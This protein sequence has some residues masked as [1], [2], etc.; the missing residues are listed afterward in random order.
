MKMKLY[1]IFIFLNILAASFF[2]LQSLASPSTKDV[3][4]ENM[5]FNPEHL[6]IHP[7]D[8]VVWNN[9]DIVSHTVTE[10]KELFNSGEVKPGAS[11]KKTFRK[12]SVISY[13]CLYHPNM[14]A[15][16]VIRK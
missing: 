15:S 13:R 16:L 1:S 11:W 10:E 8:T 7:G 5:K 4:I 14:K 2:G 3:V 6:E 9:K 12:E